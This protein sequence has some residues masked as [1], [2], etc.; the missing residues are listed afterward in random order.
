MTTDRMMSVT[1]IA[2][3][4]CV[5]GTTGLIARREL[6]PRP[7]APPAAGPS[8]QKIANWRQYGDTGRRM[9]REPGRL[10]I[11]EFSDF[12][13]PFCARL[14]DSLRAYQAK[15]PGKI[16]VLYRHYPLTAIHPKAMTA[17]IASEC[18]ARQGRFVPY[19]DALF[20]NQQ[21]LTDSLL[22]ALAREVNLG[23]VRAFD[24]CLVDRM[25]R[26]VVEAD[27]RAANKLEVT[28]TP[29]LVIGPRKVR[30]A[31]SIE[32]LDSLVNLAIRQQ[33]D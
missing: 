17:A 4:A 23:D 5:L 9:A 31:L 32:Q 11:V 16:E 12:Q 21:R 25:A 3:M 6:L 7:S 1:M 10:R 29:T 13:C 24:R 33:R 2:L 22:T 26:G 15:F 19:H 28:A 27:M 18:A 30:G 20:R 14:A 8:I